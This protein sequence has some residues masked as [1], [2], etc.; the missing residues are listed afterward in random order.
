MGGLFIRGMD[1]FE[2]DLSSTVLLEWA[3]LFVTVSW[4]MFLYRNTGGLCRS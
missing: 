3:V 2:C 1:T 4:P